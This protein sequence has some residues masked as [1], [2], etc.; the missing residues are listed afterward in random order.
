MM[1]IVIMF[2]EGETNNSNKYKH[3]WD[4]QCQQSEQ[5]QSHWQSLGG[6]TGV[7]RMNYVKK[8]IFKR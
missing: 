1:I 2:A 7:M 6:S 8:W 4:A 5:K 3:L